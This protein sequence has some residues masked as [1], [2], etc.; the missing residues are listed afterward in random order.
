M[1]VWCV[2]LPF[3]HTSTPH[4]S[5]GMIFDVD[6]HPMA[7]GLLIEP[8]LERSAHVFVLRKNDCEPERGINEE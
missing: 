1:N 7:C 3:D 2:I 5:I 6:N 4:V 8:W